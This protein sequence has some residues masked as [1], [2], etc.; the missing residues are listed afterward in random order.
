M[1]LK[2]PPIERKGKYLK[3]KPILR[4]IISIR[5]I[6][7]IFLV[8]GTAFCFSLASPYFFTVG[9][10]TDILRQASIIGLSA[11][12]LTFVVTCGEW[13]ISVEAM[14]AMGCIVSFQLL[15]RYNFPAW[16]TIALACALGVG[17]GA[18]NGFFVSKLK[19]NS[20]IVTLATLGMWRGVSYGIGGSGVGGKL[21]S[22]LVVDDI[23][24]FIGNRYLFHLPVPVIIWIGVGGLATILLKKHRI[25]KYIAAIGDNKIA[26][27][28]AGIKVRNVKLLAFVLSGLL[29]SFA[30][31]I[32]LGWQMGISATP[33]AGNIVPIMSATL[34]GGTSLTG[35]YGTVVGSMLGA[36]FIMMIRNGMVL[37]GVDP[38]IQRVAEASLLVIALY[39]AFLQ[40][41]LHKKR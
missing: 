12:G 4:A 18:M 19:I 26:A 24:C 39:V 9:N 35:G 20:I 40:R 3:I 13:D 37:L 14:I 28:Q 5:E 10:I 11:I 34:I 7:I 29:S 31:V 32:L 36:V 41:R 6:L 22:F 38:Y 17:M 1:K 21:S 25:G 2:G 33:A 16:I 27:I 15:Q 30:G 8:T 23:F